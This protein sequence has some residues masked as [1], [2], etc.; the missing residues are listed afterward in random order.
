M[1]SAPDFDETVA[2]VEKHLGRAV[3]GIST[4]GVRPQTAD[5][6][7]LLSI[8]HSLAAMAT[9]LHFVFTDDYDENPPTERHTHDT[10]NP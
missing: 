6:V 1:S 10:S 4:T 8:A 5:Q 3:G 2:Q 9:M 7:A